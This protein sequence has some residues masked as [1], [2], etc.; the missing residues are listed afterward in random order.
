M[1]SVV[2]ERLRLYLK[3]KG[4]KNREVASFIGISETTLNN[5]LNGTRSLD[6]DT[7]LN[8]IIHFE[9]LSV[10]WLLRGSGDMF[11][12]DKELQTKAKREF[13]I[14]IDENGFLKIK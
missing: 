5:K 13:T 8:I 6:L 3:N 7:L 4:I 10:E 11:K 1:E 14:I 9:D 12:P 2:I